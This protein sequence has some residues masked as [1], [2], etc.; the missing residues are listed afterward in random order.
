MSRET[1]SLY[2]V[3]VQIDRLTLNNDLQL[4]QL[5]LAARR[6]GHLL[7]DFTICISS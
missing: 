6:I 2:S 1:A 5:R 4:P 7:K 3:R